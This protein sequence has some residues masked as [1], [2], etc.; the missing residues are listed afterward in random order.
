MRKHGKPEPDCID[1]APPER[2]RT[3]QDQEATV[4]TI[5]ELPIG[6]HAAADTPPVVQRSACATASSWSMQTFQPAKKPSS[7]CRAVVAGSGCI[8]VTT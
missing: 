1:A 4:A 6:A 7:S 2:R 8:T 5:G 3:R